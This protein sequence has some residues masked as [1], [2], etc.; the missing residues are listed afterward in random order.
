MSD[1]EFVIPFERLPRGFAESVEHPPAVPA[2]TR[3]AATVV[4]MRDG[5]HGPEALL[6]RRSRSAAFVPGAY[7]FPGGRVDG[8]DA[9]PEL[10]ERLDG[11]DPAR[12]AERL[13]LEG[14]DPPAIAYYLAAVREAFEET[15][16]L[17]GRLEDGTAPPAGEDDPTVDAMRRALLEDRVGFA[18]ALDVLGCR[19]AGDA[20]AYVA[21]WITPEAE[22]RRYDTRF[23][24]A[25]V[26]EGS[27]ATIDS[28]E[29][30]DARWL[31]P[32]D[33]LRARREGSLPLIFPTIRTL[34]SLAAFPSVDA[35]LA[36]LGSRPVPA[37][38]PRL[39]VTPT[40][41][42]MEMGEGG[43]GG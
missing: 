40:G 8:S 24:L 28:R 7:V 3:P 14:G 12:A 27:R 35:A 9:G 31:T 42:G 2:A 13:G 41:V 36:E 26:P 37:I 6:L 39:V 29:M 5:E 30:T 4:L 43:S 32:T 17:V 25:R 34:E 21:H 1:A 16:L 11:L 15:G 23:F 10:L 22:P 38:M 18:E 20:I 33:A 19:V